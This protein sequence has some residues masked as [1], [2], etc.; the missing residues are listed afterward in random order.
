MKKNKSPARIVFT[1][2]R[3]R[4]NI[5]QN[6]LSLALANSIDWASVWSRPGQFETRAT[7]KLVS[8]EVVVLAYRDTHDAQP[9]RRINLLRYPTADERAR[10]LARQNHPTRSD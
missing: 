1:S 7:A 6:G 3:E 10:F 5:A 2:E 8:G 4:S 9:V